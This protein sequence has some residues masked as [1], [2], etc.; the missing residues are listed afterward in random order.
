MSASR[1]PLTCPRTDGDPLSCVGSLPHLAVARACL[2]I[3][4]MTPGLAFAQEE[5]GA[6][7]SIVASACGSLL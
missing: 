6:G 7:L 4:V 5:A 3:H 1:G 2:S